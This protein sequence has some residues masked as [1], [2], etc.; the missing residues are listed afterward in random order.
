MQSIRAQ[1]MKKIMHVQ[2]EVGGKKEFV[3]KVPNNLHEILRKSK[4]QNIEEL[5]IQDLT[6]KMLN[7]DFN[8]IRSYEILSADT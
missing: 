5:A 4:S 7:D 6:K 3:F 8:S 1:R 2:G